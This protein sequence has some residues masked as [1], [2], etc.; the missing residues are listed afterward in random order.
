M[1]TVKYIVKINKETIKENPRAGQTVFYLPIGKP[2][3]E[4]NEDGS[5][6]SVVYPH[7]IIETLV[8]QPKFIYD[9]LPTLVK[10]EFCGAEFDYNKLESED[11]DDYGWSE[12]VCPKC[13]ARDCC[14][15][16]FEKL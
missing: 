9:Y 8:P 4:Y 16:E 7:Q 14:E 2:V 15:I 12:N 13:H 11:Y 5:I 10:C 1:L 6:K 3:T